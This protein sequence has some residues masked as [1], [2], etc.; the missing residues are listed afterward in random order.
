[1]NLTLTD[2]LTCPRCGE[3]GLILLA[4]RVEGRRVIAGQLG[5]PGCRARYRVEDG[6]ADLTGTAA[7]PAAPAEMADAGRVAALLGVTEGPAMLLLLGAYA[8]VAREIATIIPEVEVIVADTDFAPAPDEPGVSRIRIGERIPLRDSSM[9]GVLVSARSTVPI[10]E[11]VRVVRLAARVVLIDPT[12]DV[13]ESLAAHG[14]HIVAQQDD[15]VVAVR[16]S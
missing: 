12:R 9:Q 11:A 13:R 15:T 8:P 1:M 14:M 2:H 6:V 4:D 10:T 5:C 16:H 3:G 7:A